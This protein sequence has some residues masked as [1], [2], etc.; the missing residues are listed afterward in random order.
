MIGEP[1][2]RRQTLR[3][4]R[5]DRAYDRMRPPGVTVD[6]SAEELAASEVK[7]EDYP[8]RRFPQVTW[9]SRT[10]KRQYGRRIAQA[11]REG[12]ALVRHGIFGEGGRCTIAEDR[13]SVTDEE[14]ERLD[15]FG[16][17]AE[18]IES[19]DKRLT[20]MLDK[21]Q[22]APKVVQ[23]LAHEV[24]LPYLRSVLSIRNIDL[25][26]AGQFDGVDTYVTTPRV[27][28]EEQGS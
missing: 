28:P 12:F 21:L 14:V 16:E 23:I 4:G 9:V 20:D 10:G 7:T 2:H 17:P 6:V 1:K 15:D 26:M 19:M 13:L 18:A 11:D 27:I 8:M 3:H 25:H 22:E 5:L 24:L